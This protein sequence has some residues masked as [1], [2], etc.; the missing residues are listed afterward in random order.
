MN[1]LKVWLLGFLIGVALCLAAHADEHHD[2]AVAACRHVLSP[3]MATAHPIYERIIFDRCV[4]LQ[5]KVRWHLQTDQ[6]Q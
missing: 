4:E 2:Q 1:Y 5:D 3:A 6:Y